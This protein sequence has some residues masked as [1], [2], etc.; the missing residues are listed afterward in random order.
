M[1]RVRTNWAQPR[2]KGIREW[3][4]S[5]GPRW[6]LIQMARTEGLIIISNDHF[7]DAPSARHL[8]KQKGYVQTG[9]MVI[10]VFST[11]LDER[12]MANTIKLNFIS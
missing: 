3:F 11:P 9:D 8:L 1:I 2:R 6:A 5:W 10:N 7:R 12:S 4:Q